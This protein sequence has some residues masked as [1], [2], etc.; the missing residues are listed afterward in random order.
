MMPKHDALPPCDISPARLQTYPRTKPSAPTAAHIPQG[1]AWILVI[2]D[3]HGNLNLFEK[4]LQQGMELATAKQLFVVTIG[5][6]T[7]NGPEVPRLLDRLIQLTREPGDL[8]GFFPILGNHDAACLLSLERCFNSKVDPNAWWTRWTG[9]YQGFK[10]KTQQQYCNSTKHVS[11][12]Q[13]CAQ[14]PQEHKEFL[15]GLPWYCIIGGY[16]FVHAG[17]HLTSHFSVEDQLAFLDQKDM[18][19]Y[20]REGQL[21][22]QLRMKEEGGVPRKNDPGWKKV[23]VTG[24]NKYSD[25]HHQLGSHRIGLQSGSCQRQPLHCALLPPLL[26]DG[27]DGL[28]GLPTAKEAKVSWDPRKTEG[29]CGIKFFSVSPRANATGGNAPPWLGIEAAP[30]TACPL[31]LDLGP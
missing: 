9:R 25:N 20:Q 30:P 14:Y 15:K 5:D 18:S 29:P 24:H 23:V 16:L 22:D 19:Y 2:S 3:I 13:F 1:D 4:A 31:V 8:L 21:P 7:D 10:G 6:Y 12:Q 11:R 26:G 17:L 27:V 28:Q